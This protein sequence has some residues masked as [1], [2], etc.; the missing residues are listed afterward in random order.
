MVQIRSVH[1]KFNDLRRQAEKLRRVK[2]IPI[3]PVIFK[4]PLKLIHELQAFQIEL[5][6]QNDELQRSNQN[7][8]EI[9]KATLNSMI[10][11]R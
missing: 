3:D 6:L 2:N 9:Q 8:M 4:D 1:E 7:L 10:L 11:H 5:E